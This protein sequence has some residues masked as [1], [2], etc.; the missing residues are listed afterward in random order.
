[1][2]NPACSGKLNVEV[3]VKSNADKVWEALR[4][5]IFIFPKAFPN[6]YKSVEVLEGDGIVVGSVRLIT[7]GEGSP[8]VKVSKEKI[9]VVDPQNKTFSYNIIDGDLLKYYKSFKA[10]VTVV[11]KEEGSLVKWS[12]EYEKASEEIP[13]P[14]LIKEF[15]EK[16]F[17]ELDDYL[18]KEA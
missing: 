4:D 11:P 12:C 3:E 10:H 1:M 17:K 8:I 6:D 14:S 16:N 2:A 18:A 9:E 5:F 7:Y 15:A 13:D